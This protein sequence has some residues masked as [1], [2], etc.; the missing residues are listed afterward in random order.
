M[1]RGPAYHIRLGFFQKEPGPVSKPFKIAFIGGGGIAR[2]HMKYL[3]TLEGV[4]VVAAA[5]VGEASLKKLKEEYPEVRQFGDY[6]Q[7]LKE[8]G[9]EV[10]AIDVC[11][12]NGLH[13]ENAIAGLEAGKHV[14]V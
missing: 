9:E 12:P 8:V 14:I 4:T 1:S 5:D 2:T 3:K 13:A 10:D 11:T 7:M 6:R